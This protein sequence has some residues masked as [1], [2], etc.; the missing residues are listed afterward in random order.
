M[1]K[2]PELHLNGDHDAYLGDGGNDGFPND[3]SPG[4]EIK[5]GSDIC[6]YC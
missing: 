3:D 4:N 6:S 1:A 5:T 2:N